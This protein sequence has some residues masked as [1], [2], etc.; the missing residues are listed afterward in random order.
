MKT[1]V[2][3]L[4]LVFT[5]SSACSTL[6]KSLIYGGIAGAT[7]GATAGSALSP[8][9]YS[10]TGNALIFGGMGALLGA[11][12]GYLFFKDDPENRDLPT[13]IYEEDISKSVEGLSPTVIKP[14][15]SSVYRVDSLNLPSNLKDKIQNPSIIEHQIPERSEKLGNGR[16]VII[17][18]HKAWEVS[19]E[20]LR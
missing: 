4:V 20:D 11:G 7:I 5:L 17:E 13:M 1:R 12:L 3:S 19:F 8:D 15:K 2:L 10:R 16:S 18:G 14:E 6:K 9:K